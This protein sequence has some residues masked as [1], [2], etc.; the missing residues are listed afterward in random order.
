MESSA[1]LQIEDHVP[2]M[3]ESS[4]WMNGCI[5]GHIRGKSDTRICSSVD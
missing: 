4:S 3:L 1:D 2:E 5:R